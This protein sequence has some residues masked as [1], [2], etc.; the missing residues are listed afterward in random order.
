MKKYL[1]IFAS[2]MMLAVVSSCSNYEYE[3]PTQVVTLSLDCSLDGTRANSNNLYNQLYNKILSKELIADSYVLKFT[4]KTTGES[5]DVRGNWN[6]TDAVSINTG[7][8]KVT[9]SCSAYGA[10]IQD[11][12][13][14]KF[15]TEATVTATSS[16]LVLKADYD[17]FLLI[18]DKKVVSNAYILYAIDKSNVIERHF[19]E[20]DNIL[21]GFS[22]SLYNAENASN[23]YLYINYKDDE[24]KQIS[25]KNLNVKNGEYYI[26]DEYPAGVSIL[27]LNWQTP[28]FTIDKMVYGKL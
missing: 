6:S 22:K 20:Y 24:A 12:C 11:K 26:F 23:Q 1:V 15:D 16:K 2:L 13:S 19:F 18:F 9:G 14:I 21:Y 8:Y 27:N 4:N 5:F 3:E 28:T 17:C 25:T 10:G 7:T